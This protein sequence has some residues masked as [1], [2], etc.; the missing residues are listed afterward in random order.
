MLWQENIGI[1]IMLTNLEESNKR[2]CE[3]Y[4]PS[5]GSQK[6]G[7][8]SVRLENEQVLPHITIRELTVMVAS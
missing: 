6:F 4:W 7:P 8:F 1:I 2:K 5:K 3:Q